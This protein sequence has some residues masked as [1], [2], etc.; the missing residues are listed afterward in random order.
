MIIFQYPL[1]LIAI[2]NPFYK[3]F[4]GLLL[5]LIGISIFPAFLGVNGVWIV[6]PFSEILTLILGFTFV[7]KFRDEYMY[8]NI[9]LKSY[10]C[11]NN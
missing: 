1:I 8:G 3:L 2:E 5:F 9:L 4:Y 7:Y 6:V 10:N 11:I